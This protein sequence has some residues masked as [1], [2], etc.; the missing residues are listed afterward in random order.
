M[1]KKKLILYSDFDSS[2]IFIYLFILYRHIVQIQ[3][4]HD[5]TL[6]KIKIYKYFSKLSN[7]NIFI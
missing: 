3:K 7:K 5:Y 1:F 6:Q 4:K 2:I